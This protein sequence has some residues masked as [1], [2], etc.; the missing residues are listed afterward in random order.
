MRIVPMRISHARAH[1]RKNAFAYK[2][3]YVAITDEEFREG[4]KG[5]LF[6]VNGPNLF[7][8]RSKDYCDGRGEPVQWI[9]DA[10]N[11]FHI[12]AAD[13][14]IV[15]LTLP[16][17]LGY[18]FNP[19]SF[20]FCHDRDG[21]LRAVM[22]EV[23]NTFKERHFYLCCHADHRPIGGNDQ[24][25]VRK[26]FHVS[27]FLE[28]AGEYRFRFACDVERMM[29]HI[30]LFAGNKLVL[31]T[32]MSGAPEELSDWRLIKMFAL[33]PLQIVKVIGLIHW[34]ALKLYFKGIRH[35]AKPLPPAAMVSR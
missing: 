18:A 5:A 15:L 21:R 19:V 7:S 23:N 20:W 16:R 12:A 24:L 13:G 17:I 30:D 8:L 34:Q 3:G 1:P 4:K 33:S 10:L 2:L 32:S 31:A 28:T 11:R 25:L 26:V 22:A 27:P 14:H 9:R 29:A 6:S 35:H